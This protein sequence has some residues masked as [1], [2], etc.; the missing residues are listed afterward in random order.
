MQTTKYI[1]VIVTK[2]DT[3]I[4]KTIRLISR[5]KYSHVSLATDKELQEMFSFCRDNTNSPLP[6]N[7]NREELNTKVFGLFNDIPCEIYRLE[8]TDEQYENIS[9]TIE[10]FK[11]F[12]SLYTY[13]IRGMLLSG[14]HIPYKINKKFVCSVWVAHVLKKSGIILNT[15][16]HTSLIQPDD[17]RYIPC[18]EMFYKGNLKKYPDFLE[19]L[20]E[21]KTAKTASLPLPFIKLK[22]I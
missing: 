20:K 9:E 12:R 7:F 14:L 10:H 15:D 17:L 13:D 2:T 6:A 4:A 16:K 5:K 8:V 22:K 3:K 19:K 18:A 21:K 1:Y 11:Q